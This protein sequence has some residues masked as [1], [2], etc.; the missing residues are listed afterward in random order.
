MAIIRGYNL[1]SADASSLWC[2]ILHSYSRKSHK[3]NELYPAIATKHI[4]LKYY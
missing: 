4:K 3:E 2:Y 1:T